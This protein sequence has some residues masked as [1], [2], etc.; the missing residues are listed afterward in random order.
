MLARKISAMS[1]TSAGN[2]GRSASLGCAR[3]IMMVS[4]VFGRAGESRIR[5][6]H[7]PRRLR[8]AAAARHPL[9]QGDRV[10]E[11]AARSSLHLPSRGAVLAV[12]EFNAHGM[13]LVPNT[14]RLFEV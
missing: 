10:T 14:V 3:A 13:Q 11:F 6:P 5:P 2:I 12:L 8:C 4:P 7:P 1:G 9:P